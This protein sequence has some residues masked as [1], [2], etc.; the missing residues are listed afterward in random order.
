MYKTL[1]VAVEELKRTGTYHVF[2]EIVDSKVATCDRADSLRAQIKKSK[3]EYRNVKNEL[4]R[5]RER[6]AQILRMD[7]VIEEQNVS[8]EAGLCRNAFCFVS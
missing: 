2:K 6:S 4:I 7:K 5:L 1:L 3:N 8:T